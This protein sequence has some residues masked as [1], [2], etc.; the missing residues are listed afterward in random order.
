VFGV[1]VDFTAAILMTQFLH[2][3]MRGVASDGL[4]TD[5]YSSRKRTRQTAVHSLVDKPETPC[6][7]L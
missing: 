2:Q 7:V 5:Q 1:P 6:F 3:L 4:N